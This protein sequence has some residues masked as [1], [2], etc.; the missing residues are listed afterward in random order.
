LP[1]SLE[2][3]RFLDWH[4]TRHVLVDTVVPRGPVIV[5]GITAQHPAEDSD[6]LLLPSGDFFLVTARGCVIPAKQ[7]VVKSQRE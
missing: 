7:A 2:I 4:V 5:D 1:E 3:D 6:C